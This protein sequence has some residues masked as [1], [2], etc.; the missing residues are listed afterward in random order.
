[1]RLFCYCDAP[2]ATTGFG[3]SAKHVLTAL[4]E[5][6]HELV[7]FAVNFDQST[8]DRV[9]WPIHGPSNPAQDP[10]GLR[11]LVRV[12][13]SNGPFDAFWSTFDPEVPWKYS[14]TDPNTGQP[15]GSV[16]DLVQRMKAASP[17][18]RAVGWFPVDGGPLSDYE[19]GVLAGWPVFDRVVTMSP[20]VR[21]LMEW[22]LKLK[23]QQP[24]SEAIEKRVEVILHG[25]DLGSYRIPTEEERRAAKVQLGFQAEDVLVLQLERNQQRKQPW[26]ALQVMEHLFQ[27]D[28][29][30]RGRVKLYQH[31]LKDEESQGCGVGFNLPDLAWR[32]GLTAG[33]D[34]RWSPGWI[35]EEQLVD[36]VYTAADVFLSVSTGE[37]FQYPV[38]EALAMGVPVVAPRNSAREALLK[39]APNVRLVHDRDPKAQVL[40]GGYN[41]R[42]GWPDYRGLAKEL[43]HFVAKPATP[44]QRRAGRKFVE[45]H[46]R[47]EDVQKQWVDLFAQE[48][49]TQQ[50]IRRTQRVYV[51]GDEVADT[52]NLAPPPGLG[53]TI[54][55]ATAVR[56]LAKARKG[57]VL[58]RVPPGD[59]SLV[60]QAA[61]GR[62][63]DILVTHQA[64]PANFNLAELYHPQPLEGDWVDGETDRVV[65]FA[66]HLGLEPGEVKPLTLAAP[67]E[68]LNEASRQFTA[69]YGI[70][71]SQCVAV[72]PWAG[73]PSRSF[74]FPTAGQVM[75]AVQDMELTPV[76]LGDQARDCRLVGI[77]DLTG[78]VRSVLEMMAL[79]ECFGA[80]VATDTATMHLAAAVGTP[81]VAVLP[82]VKP[83]A[84]LGHYTGQVESVVPHVT[85]LA[86]GDT[87]PSRCLPKAD[88]EW[89]KCIRAADITAALRRL[90]GV[91]E[92]T[93]RLVK[94]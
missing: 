26:G 45:T 18:F 10:Y 69:T 28:P 49:A 77:V 80:V 7:Q 86:N 53:D 13:Q 36:L 54:M 87:Y 88:A 15:V 72:A 3:R 34:V 85:E 84:R 47:L 56:S 89:G 8:R 11:D 39:D 51:K 1:M 21:D 64:G 79:L 23:G 41:R 24:N 20:H 42:M 93:L 4:H 52:V 12:A 33:D 68:F 91:E 31:M 43:R 92:P 60:M 9:P 83:S 94:E 67:E 81:L 71:P 17:G 38:W 90:L 6:G 46:A 22:T 62:E 82:T 40:R 61:A 35:S 59:H 2:T 50:T 55:A 66:T 58:V 37:G 78:R 63:G 30:L 73:H 27:L 75:A 5:Q 74:P 48:E 32:Y 25:V 16:L 19:L 70:D 14:V 65:Q 44:I 57:K 76:L 29:N